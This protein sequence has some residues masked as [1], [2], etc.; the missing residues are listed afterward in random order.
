MGYDITKPQPQLFVARDFDH[1]HAVLA[2][3]SQTLAYDVGGGDAVQA[4]LRSAGALHGA[5][6]R[7]LSGDRDLGGADG[8]GGAGQLLA[9]RRVPPWR[10]GVVRWERAAHL[11]GT[12]RAARRW[13]RSRVRRRSNLARATTRRA[14]RVPVRFR[15]LREWSRLRRTYGLPERRFGYRTLRLEWRDRPPSSSWAL[16]APHRRTCRDGSR[17]VGVP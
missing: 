5:F 4:A 6:A 13:A 15:R 9:F 17:R 7:G 16:S 11:L 1:L 3:V 2:D 10:G 14:R 8:A 12:P